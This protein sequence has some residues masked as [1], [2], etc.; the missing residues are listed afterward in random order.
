MFVIQNSLKEL[1]LTYTSPGQTQRMVII[2]GYFP[3]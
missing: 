1:T 2:Q 3:G